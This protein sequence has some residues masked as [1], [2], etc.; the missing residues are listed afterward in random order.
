MILAANRSRRLTTPHTSRPSTIGR[1]RNPCRNMIWPA[2]STEVSG[3]ADCGSG[4]IH[5]ETGTLVRSVPDAA[6]LSTSRSVRIPARKRPCI[7]KAEPTFSRT[8]AAAACATGLSGVAATTLV[9]ISS[10][11]VTT[12]RPPSPTFADLIKVGVT[13][14]STRPGKLFGQHPPQRT[15]PRRDLRPPHPE[16]LERGLV[17]LS[18]RPL[19]GN[20]IGEILKLVHEIEETVSADFHSIDHLQ[21]SGDAP[22]P[23]TQRPKRLDDAKWLGLYPEAG[24]LKR[25]PG[26]LRPGHGSGRDTDQA[27]TRIRPGHG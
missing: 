27:G 1:W 8:I 26:I 3:V 20:R 10:P 15:R 4:L 21:V 14:R 18:V 25:P 22:Q 17:K 2:S 6:A 9:C 5:A 13:L 11:T 16:Q 23:G 24:P 12:R 7:T 19:R